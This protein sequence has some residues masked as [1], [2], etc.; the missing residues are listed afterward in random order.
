M[1]GRL[2]IG[3]PNYHYLA[4]CVVQCDVCIADGSWEKREKAALECY[5]VCVCVCNNGAS[6]PCAHDSL[7]VNPHKQWRLFLSVPPL[8]APCFHAQE[9][10]LHVEWV[11]KLIPR[12]TFSVY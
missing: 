9:K 11:S 3:T 7:T 5:C 10:I 1:P 2:S 8:L 12:N 6:F 4:L